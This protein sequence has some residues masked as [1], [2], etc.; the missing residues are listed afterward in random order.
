ML[1]GVPLSSVTV[2]FDNGTVPGFVTTYVH[3][4]GVP[5]VN[6]GPAAGVFASSPFTNFTTAIS[7]TTGGTR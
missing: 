2:T 5:G 1:P 4:T 6:T 3:V 7:T